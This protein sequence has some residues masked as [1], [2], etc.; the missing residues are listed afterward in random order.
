[1]K[2]PTLLSTAF[3]MTSITAQLPLPFDGS[4]NGLTLDT[5]STKYMLH[6]F[7]DKRNEHKRK[8]IDYLSLNIEP[9]HLRDNTNEAVL[10][11]KVDDNS[12]F[13]K[14]KNFRR[15]EI[16]TKLATEKTTWMQFS[17]NVPVNF[18]NETIDWQVAFPECHCWEVRVQQTGVH[19]AQL[20]IL[21]NKSYGSPIWKT[22]L[23]ADI[24][25][26]F[27]IFVDEDQSTFY[28]SENSADLKLVGTGYNACNTTQEE[29]KEYHFGLAS[30]QDG[31]HKN[32][33]APEYIRFSGI[34]ADTKINESKI[35]GG[36]GTNSNSAE[37]NEGSSGGSTPG[38][39]N[40]NKNN[41][42]G[43]KP[44]KSDGTTPV[45]KDSGG[46]PGSSTLSPKK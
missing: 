42:N 6:I 15:S 36:G 9:R 7:L 41:I 11:I 10:Q 29:F 22:K 39:Q 17:L 28:V 37:Q 32:I 45:T 8:L 23:R 24:W 25:Y 34:M 43:G 26:N 27:G 16:V 30:Y 21:S 1:M 3:L 40:E 35:K 4:F 33:G 18:R 12:T 2:I 46:S 13:L 31:V 14:Q 44:P 20:Q 19:D 5:L 38:D